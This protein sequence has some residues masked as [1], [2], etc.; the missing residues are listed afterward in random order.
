VAWIFTVLIAITALW[1][2]VAGRGDEEAA[3]AI[4]SSASPPPA[5]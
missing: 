1:E 2:T 3:A 4:S 5:R